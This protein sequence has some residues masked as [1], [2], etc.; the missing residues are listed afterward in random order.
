MIETGLTRGL[1]FLRLTLLT[2]VA[3]RAPLPGAAELYRALAAGRGGPPGPVFYLSTSPWNLHDLLSDFIVRRG[4]PPGPLLLT[5]WGPGRGAFF[6]VP[7]EEHKLTLIGQV[8][9]DHPAL[10]VVLVGDTG[11]LDPE[12]YASVAEQAPDRIAAVY[13][14]RTVGISPARDAEVR[15]LARRV[16]AGGVP[17]LAVDDSVQIAEHARSIGLLDRPLDAVRRACAG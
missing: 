10:R 15:D 3:D 6:R 2:E 1:A 11:Q 13:V 17:M 16:S 5:D 7:A 9:A 4:F 14:R 12:I 8:L